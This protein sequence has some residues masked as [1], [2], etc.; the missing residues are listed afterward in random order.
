MDSAVSTIDY[1]L[2]R[3]GIESFRLS[4]RRTLAPGPLAMPTLPAMCVNDPFPL[5]ARL[6]SPSQDR[7]GIGAGD[8]VQAQRL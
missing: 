7:P 5:L 6:Y 3:K 2:V 8:L 1:I 4:E